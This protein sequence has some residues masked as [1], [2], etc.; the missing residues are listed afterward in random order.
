M[1][2]VLTDR[3]LEILQ[4]SPYG[5]TAREVAERLGKAADNISSRKVSSLPMGSSK[6]REAGFIMML[7]YVPFI[8]RQ[9]QH[10]RRQ[11]NHH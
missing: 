3:V 8:M 5:L 2:P 4:S 6:R 9:L 11:T 10:P 1:L 7:P